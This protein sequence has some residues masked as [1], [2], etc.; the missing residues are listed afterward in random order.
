MFHISLFRFA[1]LSFRPLPYDWGP[2]RNYWKGFGESVSGYIIKHNDSDTMDEITMQ[3][4]TTAIDHNNNDTFRTTSNNA[5][6]NKTE[7]VTMS[8]DQLGNFQK[9]NKIKY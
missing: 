3:M 8:K 2:T 7:F 5:I 1:I 6:E 4:Q 9:T